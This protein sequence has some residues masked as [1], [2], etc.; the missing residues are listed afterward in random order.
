MEGRSRGARSLEPLRH[1][2][3]T[4]ALR[5]PAS[6]FAELVHLPAP[7]GLLTAAGAT[8]LSDPLATSSPTPALRPAPLP[9]A[10]AVEQPPESLLFSAPE[11]RPAPPPTP[12]TSSRTPP[13]ASLREPCPV[14]PSPIRALECAVSSPS[15]AIPRPL[16]SRRAFSTFSPQLA[17]TASVKPPLSLA[18]HVFSVCTARF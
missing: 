14:C 13:S 6:P 2:G 18:R 8:V 11:P 4:S 16:P 12:S 1:W 15:K 10:H 9:A 3:R 5:T 7:F 17:F